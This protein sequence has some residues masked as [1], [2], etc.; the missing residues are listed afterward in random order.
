MITPLIPARLVA[1][2]PQE[3]TRRREVALREVIVPSGM[4]E[5]IR[6]P[7]NLPVPR[8]PYSIA[9]VRMTLTAL[10]MMPSGC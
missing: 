7:A 10:F 2:P 1:C 6:R 4:A 8:A 3:T 9:T 5:L